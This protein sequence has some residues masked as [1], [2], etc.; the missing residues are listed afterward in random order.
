MKFYA[1]AL[2]ANVDL[3]F[4]SDGNMCYYNP[5]H[6]NQAT[7]NICTWF[8]SIYFITCCQCCWKQAIKH[9]IRAHQNIMQFMMRANSQ[10]R[11]LL[12]DCN[13]FFVHYTIVLSSFCKLFWRHWIYKMPVRYILSSVWARL[14]ILSQLTII[15]YAGL[16]VFSLPISLLMIERIHILCLIIILKSEV[17][18]ITHCLGLGH[19]TMVCTVCLSI[20]LWNWS[21][22]SVS[23]MNEVI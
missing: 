20:F 14:S 11:F 21:C 18:T 1:W 19:E 10:V 3:Q 7:A 9:C 2:F 5:F 6:G 8:G 13:H 22:Q 12:A 4:R 17:W 16:C 23:Q 15:E